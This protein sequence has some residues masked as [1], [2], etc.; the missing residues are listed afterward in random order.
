MLKCYQLTDLFSE[1]CY[2][3]RK[4]IL[5]WSRKLGQ[6]YLW[7]DKLQSFKKISVFQEIFASTMLI[8]KNFSLR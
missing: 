8:L 1:I 7:L 5:V 4:F 2:K 3:K 6:G